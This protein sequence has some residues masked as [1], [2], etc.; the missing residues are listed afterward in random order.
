MTR[1]SLASTLIACL[2]AASPA[3]SQPTQP[4]AG[5]TTEEN[6]LVEGARAD[7]RAM[8]VDTINRAGVVPLARFEDKI[9]PGV[10]GLAPAPAEKVL[11]LIRADIAALGGNLQNIGCTANATVIFTPEPAEFVRKLAVKQPGFFNF[12]PAGLKQFTATPRPVVSWHVTEVRDRDGNELGNTRELGMAKA[13]ILNQTAA[14]GVPMNARVLRNTGATHLYTSSRE[15][16]LFG[17]AVVDSSR[18]QGKTM[19]QLAALATL[20]LMLDIKQNAGAN[21]PA[22]ILSLFD[23]RAAG[24]AVPDGLSSFDR[25]MIEGLY[26]PQEN[27][28]SAVQQLSQIAA[29]V[30]KASDR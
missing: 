27:N 15:D 24:A 1:I 29:A 9:C 2:A 8:V 25:A 5:A 14:A 3:A 21:N 26:R 17:F 20:H 23:E 28:R 6:I 12:S 16:M 11:Q 22:S 7:P 18:I 4:Q 19:E 10:V 30:R 13:K